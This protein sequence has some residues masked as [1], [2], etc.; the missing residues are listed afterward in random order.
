[1]REINKLL[2]IIMMVEIKNYKNNVQKSEIDKFYRD[3]DNPAN[4]DIQCAVFASLT[5]G[6]C[7]REDF[8]FESRNGIPI[9]FIHNL[10]NNFDKL[11]LASLMFKAILQSESIDLKSKTIID[12]FKTLSAVIKRTFKNQKTKLDKFHSEQ[13]ELIT[14]QQEMIIELYTNIQVKY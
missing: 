12:K 5:S 10:N 13:N 6:I 2:E 7:S 3:I 8:Q 14:Q 9:L 11:K 1:M 4:N